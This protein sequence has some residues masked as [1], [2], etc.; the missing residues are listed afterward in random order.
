MKN[1]HKMI[2][3]TIIEITVLV[4]LC[5]ISFVV[6][7]TSKLEN[8]EADVIYTDIDV[9]EARNLISINGFPEDSQVK[10]R[11][12]N[13]SNT[14][15][16]YNVL[17][18]SNNDLSKYEDCLKI[19]INNEE[20]LLKDLKV[21]NNYFLIDEGNMKATVKKIDLY[22]TFDEKYDEKLN[23]TISLQFV[24]DVSI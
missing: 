7:N 21:A 23:N 5:L 2:N 24:N 18:T 9:L 4:V 12:S 16:K 19:K 20:Y 8:V 10:L 13:L 6:F 14:F 1:I 15:E 17:L 22:F 11:V 3:K